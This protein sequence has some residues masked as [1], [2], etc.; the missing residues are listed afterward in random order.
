MPPSRSHAL[1]C[2][3]F[4]LPL[5]VVGGLVATVG[6]ACTS[7]S[8]R[9]ADR[10]AAQATSTTSAAAGAP[11]A[12]AIEIKNFKFSPNPLH[13]KAGTAIEVTNSDDTAH[14]VTADGGSK[15]MFDTKRL[16]GGGKGTVTISAPGTY[17]FHCDI[18]NYMTGVIQVTA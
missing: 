4:A 11:D 13:A 5:I 10:Q 15:E 16:A 12:A 17:K 6:T 14:T 18:H 2:P 3:A 1:R 8:T 9:A 7:N